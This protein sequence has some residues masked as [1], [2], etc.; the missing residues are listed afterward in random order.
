V[1]VYMSVYRHECVCVCVCVCVRVH[2][3]VV[4][5]RGQRYQVLLKLELQAVVSQ[6]LWVPGIE[7][8]SSGRTVCAFGS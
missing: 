8:P 1:Y 6:V 3:S 5:H 2:M 7:L 4:P